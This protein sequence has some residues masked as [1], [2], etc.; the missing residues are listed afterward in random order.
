MGWG[1]LKQVCDKFFCRVLS[2]KY[3]LQWS[4]IFSD[5]EE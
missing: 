1:G 2:T 4:R 3:L 5:A